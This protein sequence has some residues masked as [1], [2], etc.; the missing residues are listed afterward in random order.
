MSI[1]GPVYVV[2]YDR[3]LQESGTVIRELAQFAFVATG[4]KPGPIG[5]VAEW[6]TPALNHY[7]Q[8]V[9]A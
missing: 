5:P 4:I 3:L 9:K 2:D 6:V 1:N 8:G 7:H